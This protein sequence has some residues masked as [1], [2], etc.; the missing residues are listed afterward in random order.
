MNNQTPQRPSWFSRI[1]AIVCLVAFS[2]P[3]IMMFLVDIPTDIREQW[4]PWAMFF[5]TAGILRMLSVSIRL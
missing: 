5:F 1:I 4:Q 2:I 3:I